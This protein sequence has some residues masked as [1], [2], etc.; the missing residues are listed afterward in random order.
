MIIFQGKLH[1]EE[2]YKTNIADDWALGVSKKGW[3]TD[4][5]TFHWLN[6]VFDLA[7]YVARYTNL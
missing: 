5:H 4:D 6:E 2:W 3:T 1:P 7:G